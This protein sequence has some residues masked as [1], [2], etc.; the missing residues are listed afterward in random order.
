MKGDTRSMR[1]VKNPKKILIIEDDPLLSRVLAAQIEFLGYSALTA[2]RWK[3]A[4]AILATCEPA[5]ILL[6]IKL[7]DANGAE[8]V[9]ELCEICPVIVLT[10]FGT[11]EE[12]VTA[13]KNGAE[14]FLLKPLKPDTISLAIRRT[15]SVRNMQR[16]YRYFV[17]QANRRIGSTLIGKS[18][19]IQNTR[20]LISIVGPS[21]TTVLILGES[22]V[23]KELIASEVHKSSPRSSGNLVAVDCSTLP[24]D[25]FESELFGHERGAFTGADRRK[26]GLVEVAS[27]GT[28]FLDEIGELAPQQQAKLLRVIETG[29]FRRVGGTV[30]LV[31][32][33]RF[34]AAT[35]RNLME[36]CKN[37]D[38]RTD[39]YYRLSAFVILVPALRERLEDVP[40]L[41]EHFLR[42]MK[43]GGGE[44]KRWSPAALNFLTGYDWPGN[45]R[46]LRNVIERA[47]LFARG[48]DEIRPVHVGALGQASNTG[49][50]FT[51]EFDEPPTIDALSAN[52]LAR[53]MSAPGHSR[54]DVAR[55]L[56]IS[57]SKLY[58]MLKELGAAH[59]STAQEPSPAAQ[60]EP[61]RAR[62][63]T[64]AGA[65]PGLRSVRG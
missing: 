65:P 35:N 49:C 60:P 37:G 56:G 62:S 28:V 34:I 52:Y 39:L 15:I 42:T 7:P 22:G 40:L 12:A 8:K 1:A 46:E 47:T 32:N 23:G 5:L 41:A 54:A 6:D 20:E 64:T 58:R 30:D 48:S 36:M 43:I 38:F 10:A 9:A 14:E 17:E 13:M 18:L 45:V 2:F 44:P 33:V 24:Y 61:R 53:L 63:G 3:E 4:K 29:R 59:K 11:V 27:G 31:A 21:D 26:E 57:Q 51:L 19:A 55:I 25:L 50:R 16:D